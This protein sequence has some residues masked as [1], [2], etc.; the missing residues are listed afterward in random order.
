MKKL[1]KI[2]IIFIIIKKKK[3]KKKVKEEVKV[4]NNEKEEFVSKI[5]DEE[6]EVVAVDASKLD[7][8]DIEEII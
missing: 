2:I 7:E 1:K 4:E 8:L 6:A 5:G 3:N